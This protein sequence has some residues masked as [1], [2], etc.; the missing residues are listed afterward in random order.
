MS[1]YVKRGA[2]ASFGSVIGRE[3]EQ[4]VATVARWA[5]ASAMHGEVLALNSF[6]ELRQTR[7]VLARRFALDAT[8]AIEIGA[9][10]QGMQCDAVRLS[11]R[12]VSCVHSAPCLAQHGRC[13]S[14]Q[15]R[16]FVPDPRLRPLSMLARCWARRSRTLPPCAP[17]SLAL[18]PPFSSSCTKAMLSSAQYVH[19]RRRKGDV[20]EADD[21]VQMVQRHTQP[22]F[23]LTDQLPRSSCH[24][25]ARCTQPAKPAVGRLGDSIHPGVPL[26]GR[27]A[28]GVGASEPGVGVLGGAGVIRSRR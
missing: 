2:L 28:D 25:S 24:S 19:Q 27:T 10:R 12:R 17:S 3:R 22:D 4:C 15:R 20:V 26:P 8:D 1:K 9:G 13:V 14:R 11:A 18:K 7:E 6:R 16:S 5:A 23:A 21:R